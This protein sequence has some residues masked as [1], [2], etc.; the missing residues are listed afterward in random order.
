MIETQDEIGG[1]S[2]MKL[3]SAPAQGSG[4]RIGGE[5][6]AKRNRLA[7]RLSAAVATIALLHAAQAQA[8]TYYWDTN[9]SATGFGTASGTW[10]APTTG[11]S[12]QGWSTSST[13]SLTPGTVTTATT[14][15]LNF[16][17]TTNTLGAGTI[18][19]ANGTTVSSGNITFGSGSGAI[20]VGASG[21]TG[22]IDVADNP[23][24]TTI[25][26]NNA[27]DT[28][29]A[30]F[31]GSTGTST[32]GQPDL[33]VAGTGNLT[34]AQ[35][36]GGAGTSLTQTGS[37]TTTLSGNGDN[38]DLALTVS[39]GTVI[40]AKSSSTTVHAFGA[41]SSIA[42]G[43]TLQLGST[44]NYEIYGNTNLTVNSGGVFDLHGDNQDYNA[45]A[46]HLYLN[47][48]GVSSNGA[49]INSAGSTTS[50]IT[51][52][53]GGL[54]LQL[55]SSIGGAGNIAISG[56]VSG[57]YAL[58]KVG[59]G[60][61]TLNS[62]DTYSGD[63][64]ISNGNIALG[65]ATALQDSAYDTTGST[66]AIGLN[67]TG[68]TTPTLGGLKGSVAL[69]TAI[70]GYGS[71]TNLNLNP[72]SGAT[73][74][75]SGNIANGAAGMTVTIAAGSSG[76]QSFSGV[77][78]YSGG[79][80]INGGT[81]LANSTDTTSGS[82]GAGLVTVAS[83]GTLGGGVGT[84][85]G[86]VK[87]NITVNNGGILTAGAGVASA[88]V[89][90]APGILN[91]SSGT[92]TLS[93]GS[94]FDVKVDNVSGSAV[95]GTN[96]DEIQMNL[97]SVSSGVNI[98][99][100][101]LTSINKIGAT[102]NFSQTSPFTLK[103]ATIATVNQST[104][105]GELADF[106]LDTSNFTSGNTTAYAQGFSLITVSDF[107]GSGSDLEIQYSGTPEPGTAMLV[108][109]GITPLVLGRRRRRKVAQVS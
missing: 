85:A 29:N 102:P 49:L 15:S 107:S 93:T 90:A 96:W 74:S 26:V 57:N 4:A 105:N 43:A 82:T 24:V 72:Q 73:P 45:L 54:V 31:N 50:T 11:S 48:T 22:I 59:A 51:F 2:D 89:A 58:T 98:K 32:T 78:S 13:G 12:T 35:V 5:A 65:I 62:A 106:T 88:T 55:N 38:R 80:T 33:S 14:D 42:S 53:T 46:G 95:A 87:G 70:T 79:T 86:I 20:V 104:L 44:T 47:G 66:G 9:G 41:N 52:G 17:S 40:L 75:Y 77:N 60:T 101:G 76:T 21:T 30:G 81:L 7:A 36:Y 19:V 109:S 94:N 83:G 84:T 99:L 63:T 67:V 8:T 28:I 100:Y 1:I 6:D 64:V 97:L 61:L 56:V 18:T 27:S 23:T 39:N 68:F 92:T 34:L 10:A 3:Y 69:A 103:I 25:T 37:G 91:E 108:I 16:G 71:V